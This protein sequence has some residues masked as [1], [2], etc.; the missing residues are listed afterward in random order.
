MQ[1][2]IIRWDNERGFGFVKE[3]ITGTEI[4]IHIST[5]NIR[6]PAPEIG[7][8]IEFETTFNEQKGKTEVKQATYLDKN[9]KQIPTTPKVKSNI[10]NPVPEIV[11]KIEFETFN[12]QKGK[13]EVKQA[14]YLDKNRKQIPI[15]HKAK[16][17]TSHRKQS[18]QNR[19]NQ[20]HKEEKQ[21]IWLWI[22]VGII[23]IAIIL[24]LY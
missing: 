14:T 2:T 11:E 20:H 23:V 9:R 3:E 12:E 4:F 1:G 17:H 24:G 10:R 16:K 21:P 13:T 7:E 15:T 18:K 19:P 22:V 6:N 8:K 5:L